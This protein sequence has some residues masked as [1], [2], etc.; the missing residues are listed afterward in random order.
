MLF[1]KKATYFKVKLEY[2][3][4]ISNKLYIYNLLLALNFYGS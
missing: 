3:K 2:M 1:V 4:N